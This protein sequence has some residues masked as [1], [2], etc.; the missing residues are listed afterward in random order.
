M[1]WSAGILGAWAISLPASGIEPAADC[2]G[3]LAPVAKAQKLSEDEHWSRTGLKYEHLTSNKLID[4]ERCRRSALDYLICITALNELAKSGS[5]ERMVLPR[6]LLKAYG[7]EI[8]S[9]DRRYGELALVRLKSTGSSANGE[10]IKDAFQKYMA[11]ES[12]YREA[13]ERVFNSRPARLT[14][15]L[16]DLIAMIRDPEKEASQVARA[17]NAAFSLED[18]HAYLVP[19]SVLDEREMTAGIDSLVGIGIQLRYLGQ[20][21]VIER[22][23]S[24]GPAAKAGVH[25]GDI[26][27]AIDGRMVDDDN[28][29]DLV[30]KIEGKAG[31]SVTLS[32]KRKG[33]LKTIRIVRRR[34]ELRNVE[35][36]LLA[37]EPGRAGFIHLRS[38]AF[39]N[40][41]EEVKAAI[42]GLRDQGAR[43][44]ILDLRGNPG[45]L[46]S[47]AACIAGLFL[48]K[49]IVA[50]QQSIH[51]GP[52]IPTVGEHRKITSLPLVVLID[53]HSASASELVAGALRDHHR[54]WIVGERSFGKG[55]VQHA[56]PFDDQAKI[57]LFST[58]ERFFQP[59]GS[60]NQL[61]GITPNIT[62]HATPSATEGEFVARE[63]D[64]YTNAIPGSRKQWREDRANEVRSLKDC[65]DSKGMAARRWLELTE[66][67][68]FADFQMLKAVDL[69]NCQE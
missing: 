1:K 6:S 64:M 50:T 17:F 12:Q 14:E 24:G 27:L 30:G 49:E 26:I 41:C 36:E 23:I 8:E 2:V 68:D 62:V 3:L 65:M 63:A 21:L 20:R 57:I 48:G 69:L 34:L 53:G 47:Q 35:Y 4:E 28:L 5:E 66:S 31:T 33:E 43:K 60:S 44:L 42:H 10:S 54:A 56:I 67:G 59:S 40:A 29:T 16:D 22:A 46:L 7:D 9:I 38:F 61:V 37:G 19:A 55:T 51:R 15:I 25:A 11:R 52:H 13:L 39:P 32:I 18:P 45:G 58:F